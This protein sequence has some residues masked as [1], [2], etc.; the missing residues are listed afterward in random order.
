MTILN[1]NN[2]S[3]IMKNLISTICLLLVVSFTYAQLHVVKNVDQNLN[4]A[5]G[6]GTSTPTEKLDVNGQL[7]VKGIKGVGT[8]RNTAY[9][10]IGRY[11][12]LSPTRPDKIGSAGINLYAPEYNPDDATNDILSH[13]RPVT[14]FA[15][16][17]GEV[18]SFAHNG[19]GHFQ[20]RSWN[21]ASEIR[22][23]TKSNP[24]EGPQQKMVIKPGLGYVGIGTGSPTAKLEVKGDAKKTN[25]GEWAGTSDKRAKKNINQYDKG[26]AE[27]LKINPVTY[28]Y[29]GKA[30]IEDTET[31]FV[32]MLA[33]EFAEI[34]PD[35]VKPFSHTDKISNKTEEFL[36]LNASSVKYMLVNAVKEQQALIEAQN[37]K[38]KSMEEKMERIASVRNQTSTP[39]ANEIS[40][41]LEGNGKE[42]ALLAQNMP[43]PFTTSTRI[44]YFIPADSRN[45]R[46][47]F[48]D[49][50]GK[51]IK[52]VDITNDGIGAIELTAQDLTAGIYSY[53]LYLDGD[54]VD[55]KKMIAK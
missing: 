32:G 13:K 40:V 17:K 42:Q 25:G 26:L 7:S 2:Q 21:R 34:E 45:A 54:I 52:R 51:E 37:A 19:K 24:G 3:K 50:A 8:S 22:F 28:N 10:S 6:I 31:T 44:E 46:M 48:R 47:S 36:S 18:T 14:S 38:I 49:M 11:N 39:T 43:N 30:G 55:S 15:A 27:V 5:V 41:L 29:N 9:V 1:T 16:T 33:Q 35:A 20:L 23:V 12:T 4:G 53:V